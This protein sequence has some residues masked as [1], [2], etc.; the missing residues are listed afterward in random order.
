M[1]LS[2]EKQLCMFNLNCSSGKSRNDINLGAGKMC[3]VSSSRWRQ[4]DSPQWVGKTRNSQ[5]PLEPW[6]LEMAETPLSTELGTR[7]RNS[8]SLLRASCSAHQQMGQCLT[9]AAA[10]GM[11]QE[12]LNYSWRRTRMLPAS[13]PCPGWGLAAG[14]CPLGYRRAHLLSK[15]GAVMSLRLTEAVIQQCG[16]MTPWRHQRRVCRDGACLITGPWSPA[17]AAAP[18][19]GASVPPLSLWRGGIAR[20][21]PRETRLPRH[22]S[23]VSLRGHRLKKALCLSRSP[24]E[25]EHAVNCRGSPGSCSRAVYLAAVGGSAR[26]LTPQRELGSGKTRGG[27]WTGLAQ[28][29]S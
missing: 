2:L 11:K 9:P 25:K 12:K 10:R 5:Y 19:P 26:L 4:R 13:P 24:E 27:I 16:A 1:K 28:S 15:S 3:L 8:L 23:L 18:H 6:A 21:A 17:W 20:P 29:A 22:C 7:C 14:C